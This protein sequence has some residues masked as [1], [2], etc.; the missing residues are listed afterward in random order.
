MQP[1]LQIWLAA[2]SS[3]GPARIR[4]RPGSLASAQHPPGRLAQQQRIARARPSTASSA[5]AHFGPH[6]SGRSWP[7]N[8]I[9]CSP[10]MSPHQNPATAAALH[11]NPRL[12]FPV[13]FLSERRRPLA[14][15]RWRRRRCTPTRR[16]RG[17]ARARTPSFL[18]PGLVP[19]R[20]EPWSPGVTAPP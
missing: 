8:Q 17:L 11:Q 6:R 10:W 18:P 2:L 7:S 4:S 16:L 1:I 14:G 13:P 12:I 9:R 3:R 5:W 19:R 15:R 20:G